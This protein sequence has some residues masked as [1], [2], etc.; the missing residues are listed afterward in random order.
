MWIVPQPSRPASQPASGKATIIV[1][2]MSQES[3]EIS[4]ARW[5]DG[6]WWLYQAKISGSSRP[7]ARLAPS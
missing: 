4:V 1:M 3:T 5:A 6:T 7:V 2:E